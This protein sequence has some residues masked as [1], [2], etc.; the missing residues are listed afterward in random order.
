MSITKILPFLTSTRFWT[1]VVLAV[2]YYLNSKLL[3]QQEI[4]EALVLVLAGSIGI[5]TLDKFSKKQ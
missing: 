5:R 4:F 1:L 3:I 2:L